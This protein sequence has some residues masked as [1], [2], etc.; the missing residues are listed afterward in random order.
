MASS[1]ARRARARPFPDSRCADRVLSDRLRE[2]RAAGIVTLQHSGGYRLTE[3][4]NDL[5]KALAPV[6][7]WANRWATL[8]SRRPS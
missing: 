5:L 6:D 8:A 3:D 1:H 4:G 2:L 7:T